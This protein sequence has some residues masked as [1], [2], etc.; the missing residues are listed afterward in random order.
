MYLRKKKNKLG[1]IS[2]QII[3]KAS[4]Y[5]ELLK[6]KGCGKTEQEVQK[7]VYKGK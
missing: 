7:V 2:V 4:G 3:T 6:T 1:T 5:Y